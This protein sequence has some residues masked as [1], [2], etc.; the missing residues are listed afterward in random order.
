MDA[1][2]IINN[3]D[4]QDFNPKSFRDEI[5]INFLINDVV[6]QFNERKN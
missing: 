6:R 5:N 4:K 1:Q 2:M 3:S